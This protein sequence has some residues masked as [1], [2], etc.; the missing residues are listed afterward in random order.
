MLFDS[1]ALVLSL[2]ASVVAKWEADER[3]TYG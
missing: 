3:F 1:T 2:G